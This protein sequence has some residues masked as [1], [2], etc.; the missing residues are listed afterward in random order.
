MSGPVKKFV[1]C[2]FCEKQACAH[3]EGCKK[4]VCSEHWEDA[5]CPKH[6]SPELTELQPETTQGA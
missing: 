3:C 6:I 4:T 5:L 2:S 1:R